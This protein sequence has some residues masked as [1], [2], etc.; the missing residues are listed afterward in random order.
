MSNDRQQFAETLRKTR[1]ESRLTLRELSKRS[2]VSFTAISAIEHGRA[3]AGMKTASKLADGLDLQGEVRDGFL[4]SA[5]FSSRKTNPSQ[6]SGAPV[7]PFLRALPW[8]L[9]RI[10]QEFEKIDEVSICC[11]PEL[12]DGQSDMVILF[13][14]KNL[15]PYITSKQVLKPE[16]REFFQKNST[17]H[18]LA[19]LVRSDHSQTV[20]S[21]ESRTF[22]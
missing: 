15:N 3:I 4:L 8:I 7:T 2:K 19:V 21:C 1:E 6:A 9:R 13:E 22:A 18:H 12:P 20:I 11:L 5:S 17:S 14:H 10:G 16:V